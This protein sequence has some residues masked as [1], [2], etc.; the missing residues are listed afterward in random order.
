[1]IFRGYEMKKR[2]DTVRGGGLGLFF[3]TVGAAVNV[4]RSVEAGRMPEGRALKALGIDEKA[5]RE[6]HLN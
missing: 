1:M 5:F 6:I 3:S 4:A 2:S